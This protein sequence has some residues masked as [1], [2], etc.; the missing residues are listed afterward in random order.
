MKTP[1][2]NT[3]NTL[4]VINKSELADHD[5]FDVLSN[6]RSE[7]VWLANFSSQNTK[8]AY[9]RSVASFIATLGI[10]SPDELYDVKQAHVLAWRASLETAGLSQATIANR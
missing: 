7:N 5:A 1:K 4:I 3:P 10:N 8:D 9:Q 6:V 2:S